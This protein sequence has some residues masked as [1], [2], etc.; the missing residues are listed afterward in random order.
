LSLGVQDFDPVVQKA[1][2][3]IQSEQDTLAMISAAKDIGY[4]SINVDLIY[5]LPFQTANSFART[6]DTIV[7]IGPQRLSIFNYAH[8]PQYFAPQKRINQQDLPSPEE[9]HEMFHQIVEKL[10]AAGYE[11]IGMD[12]FAKPDDSLVNARN[13][14]T[15]YR[16]FQG[17]SSHA[18]C[19]LIGLGVTSISKVANCYSQNAKTLDQYYGLIS[20]NR[21]PVVK[22]IALDP[23]DLIRRGIIDALMC[24]GEIDFSL[25][26]QRHCIRFKE[27]FTHELFELEQ[28]ESDGLL[29]ILPDRITVLPGGRFLIR[30][31]SMVFDAY[32]QHSSEIQRFSRMI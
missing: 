18:D 8:M 22:G 11:Y 23:D 1:I 21:L 4:Q 3:R 9:K 30:N 14:H 28:M 25:I 12:H 20:E 7:D 32:Q 15:L 10:T 6:L 24:Y 17:Y 2:H 5:G 27:Y 26:E 29:E 16:N 31:V 19:D 13:T